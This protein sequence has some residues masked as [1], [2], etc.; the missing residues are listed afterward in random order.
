MI[1]DMMRLNF[2]ENSKAFNYKSNVIWEDL[3]NYAKLF[4][5]KNVKLFLYFCLIHIKKTPTQRRKADT[6]DVIIK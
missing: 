5:K 4:W 6:S 3:N 1:L 2:V